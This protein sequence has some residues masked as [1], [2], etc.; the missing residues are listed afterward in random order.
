MSKTSAFGELVNTAWQ[1]GNF[2]AASAAQREFDAER[3]RA[4]TAE[5]RVAKLEA[6]VKKE[7]DANK[8]LE[9]VVRALREREALK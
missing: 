4:D 8:T 1:S 6:R 3:A 5:Q 2:E 9:I 7:N